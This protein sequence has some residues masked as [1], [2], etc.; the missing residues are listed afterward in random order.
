MTTFKL[1]LR[2]FMNVLWLFFT[3]SS[4]SLAQLFHCR[5]QLIDHF[6]SSSLK[7]F[8]EFNV[9]PY[10]AQR[11]CFFFQS[12]SRFPPFFFPSPLTNRNFFNLSR[13]SILQAICLYYQL[14]SLV[15]FLKLS[16]FI[17]NLKKKKKLNTWR[18]GLHFIAL[19]I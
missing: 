7:S 18:L 5:L 11:L 2:L 9:M 16:T 14:L 6:S 1:F 12:L 17:C 3:S 15:Q 4:S 13:S 10:A 8:K 19:P